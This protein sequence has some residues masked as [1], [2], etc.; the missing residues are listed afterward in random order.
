MLT[1]DAAVPLVF[2]AD[3]IDGTNGADGAWGTDILLRADPFVAVEL[4]DGQV[5]RCA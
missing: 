1:D 4:T 3:G 5:T 2:C